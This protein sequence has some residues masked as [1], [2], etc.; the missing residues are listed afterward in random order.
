MED[1]IFN[2]GSVKIGYNGVPWT[3]SS[4]PD[5]VF[6]HTCDPTTR[7][8]ESFRIEAIRAAQEIRK[9]F[10]GKPLYAMYSGGVDS[11]AMMEAF[12]LARIPVT[13]VLLEFTDGSNQHDLVWARRYLNKV[14]F[15]GDVKVIPFNIKDWLHSKECLDMARDI[16]T[17]E[18]ILTHLFKVAQDHLRDGIVMTAH[19]EPSL[20][21][22]PDIGWVWNKH[23]VHYGLHKYFMKE[24][25]SGIPSFFQWSTELLAAFI[26]NKNYTP[27]Y[28]GLMNKKIWSAEQLKYGFYN[29]Q[30]GLAPRTKYTGFENVLS[31]IIRANDA[32]AASSPLKWNREINSEIQAWGKEV[33]Y[34][35]AIR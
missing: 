34:R 5:D 4:D 11:E 6:M 33:N 15:T 18:L 2:N 9:T 20:W 24:K 30:F 13:A 28:Y 10:P 26:F 32:W 22:E 7:P 21:I 27:A 12:R 16:Q 1:L 29:S 14:S 17:L 3:F 8:V 19:E 25:L 35:R 31:D 23:E